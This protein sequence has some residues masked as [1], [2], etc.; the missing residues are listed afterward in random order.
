MKES[1][2][3]DIIIRSWSVS[4]DMIIIPKKIIFLPDNLYYEALKPNIEAREKGLP[5]PIK[6]QKRQAGKSEKQ[7]MKNAKKSK[8]RKEVSHDKDA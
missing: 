2:M 7:K 3:K 4:T 5:A 8:K 6:K 1:F